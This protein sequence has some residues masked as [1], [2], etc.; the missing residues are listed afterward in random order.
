[1]RPAYADHRD[2]RVRFGAL[3]KVGGRAG[4]P[5]QIDA[6]RVTLTE[7]A[8]WVR[9]RHQAFVARPGARESPSDAVRRK[10]IAA[11][12]MAFVDRLRAVLDKPGAMELAMMMSPES[13]AQGAAE[14][15]REAP[16][17]QVTARGAVSGLRGQVLGDTDGTLY[18]SGDR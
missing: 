12:G 17:V 3:V 5:V 9:M 8:R 4:T 16:V 11:H 6:A 14:V 7:A 18:W 10:V 13:H 1:M 15:P 2:G